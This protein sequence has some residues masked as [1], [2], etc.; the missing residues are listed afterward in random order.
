[1]SV[2]LPAVISGTNYLGDAV[3]ARTSANAAI[4]RSNAALA[5]VRNQITFEAE[6]RAM[7]QDF[8]R[9]NLAEALAVEKRNLDEQVRVAELNRAAIME[10]LLGN[11]AAQQQSL[12]EQRALIDSEQS[13]QQEFARGG[14][15]ALDANISLYQN[16][17]SQMGQTGDS[18]AALFLQALEGGAESG[19]NQSSIPAVAAREQA[20]L[21]QQRGKSQQEARSL[22]GLQSL[23]QLLSNIGVSQ[24]R[25]NQI[26]DIISN[27]AQGS[28]RT[29]QPALDA[30]SIYF[31]RDPITQQ[32]VQQKYINP[33]QF[34]Q[35]RYTSSALPTGQST[36]MLGDLLKLGS[37]LA[38]RYFA[39]RPP[40]IDYS[41][42]SG[43]DNTL[44]IPT[45][46][47][48]QG[49]KLPNSLGIK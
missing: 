16:F 38:D 27:F 19:V 8:E 31:Q 44:R 15:D 12:G 47:G 5:D 6:Q 40:Q 14:R 36:N 35:E 23:G 17:G 24:G 10:A 11:I 48:G 46:P 33:G 39:T 3:N 25:N 7:R 34:I 41:L 22:A 37:G 32:A 30:A 43:F 26:A 49:L 18:L 29:L 9:T 13:R 1:M 2:W 20:L 4:A 42:S 45:N 21:E 28:A